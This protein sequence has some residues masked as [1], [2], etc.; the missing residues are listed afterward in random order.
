MAL[1]ALSSST[2]QNKSRPRLALDN[3]SSTLLIPLAARAFGDAMFP[4][5]AAGDARA[6]SAVQRLACDLRP[7]LRDKASVFGVLART[8]I[9]RQLADD[10]FERFPN[11][12]GA[13]LGCGMACYFQWLD[14]QSNRWLDADMPQVMRLRKRLLP[15]S[16]QRHHNAEID[17][18]AAGWWQQLGLPVRDGGEPTLLLCE[19]VLMYLD[20]GQ[21]AHFLHEFGQ[22]APAGSEL[23]CDSLSWLSIGCAALHPSV[24]HTHAEFKWGPKR[25]AD[26]TA[27][28]PRL[29]LQSEHPVMEAYDFST[30]LACSTFRALWGVPAYGIVRLGV[31]G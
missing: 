16:S 15:A 8:R 21:V 7:F 23:L 12:L 11:A 13:N 19:G 17:L 2:S 20:A 30:A 3:I 29:V 25:M 22:N 14:R 27:P 5:F 1:D 31:Q 26:F 10:F 6:A 18:T 4:T 9:F 28:H 24:S